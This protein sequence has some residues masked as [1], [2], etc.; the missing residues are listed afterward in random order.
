MLIKKKLSI[1]Q[2]V[3]KRAYTVKYWCTSNVLEEE[4][5][6]KNLFK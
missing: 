2:I 5:C 1:T 4:K 3:D 6:R